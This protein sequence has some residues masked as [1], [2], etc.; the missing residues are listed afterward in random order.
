[1]AW[2]AITLLSRQ[3]TEHPNEFINLAFRAYPQGTSSIGPGASRAISD[4]Y[5]VSVGDGF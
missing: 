3:T 1:M 2:S 5:F 4:A